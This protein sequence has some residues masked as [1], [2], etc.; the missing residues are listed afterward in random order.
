M[1]TTHIVH[2]T[3]TTDRNARLK[4]ESAYVKHVGQYRLTGTHIHVEPA[5]ST[6][7][8]GVAVSELIHNSE[9]PDRLALAINCAPPDRAEGTVNNAR[10][11]FFFADLG[12][13]VYAGGT[14]NGLELSYVRDRIRALYRLTTTNSLGSQFRSLQILPEHMIRFIL[15][16]ERKKLLSSGAL[17]AVTDIGEIV[18]PVPDRTHVIEVDNF[19]N[20]KLYVAARDWDLLQK[21]QEVEFS[22]GRDSVEFEPMENLPQEVFRALVRPTLFAAPL[23]TNVL[24]L[25]SSSRISGDKPVPMIATIREH[26]ALTTPRYAVPE[27]GQPL[28]LKIRDVSSV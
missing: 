23:G 6:L 5:H 27:I 25:N 12:D 11:D 21:A 9:R 15:P 20:I 14:S 18:P 17:A 10:N 4:V 3:D 16:K 26:P 24:A 13:N 28:H 2:I 8:I 22:Y 7:D 19:K 1:K